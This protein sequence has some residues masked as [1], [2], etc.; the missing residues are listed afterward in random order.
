M[1]DL[2]IPEAHD[3]V[4]LVRPSVAETREAMRA[5]YLGSGPFTYQV[6]RS[7]AKPLYSGEI[8]LS[9]VQHA[10]R[11]RC[12]PVGRK[13][14]EDVATLLH[15]AA[16]GRSLKCYDLAARDYYIRRDIKIPVRPSLY[17][18]ENARAY[19]FWL[20]ARKRFAPTQ[21]QLG[22]LAA[23]IRD[24]YLRDDFEEADVEILDLSAPTGSDARTVHRFHLVDFPFI[25]PDEALSAFQRLADAHDELKRE[26]FIRPARPSRP[27]PPP[28][29]GLF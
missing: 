12:Q 15:S 14:N 3:A 26:G 4:R 2:P 11:T 5:H 29:P 13:P 17:F 1:S 24:T 28:P 22:L 25:S 23:I 8:S 21:A 7:C 16:R 18:I 10:C 20:Q 27:P 19:I 9:A 6:V